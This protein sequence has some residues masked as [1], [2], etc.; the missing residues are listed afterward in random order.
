[1]G[2]TRLN[3]FKGEAEV[4]G[5]LKNVVWD[6]GALTI[7]DTSIEEAYA[8]IDACAARSISAV[9][10]KMAQTAPVIQEPSPEAL[11]H[12][13]ISKATDA[14]PAPSTNGT[15]KGEV[16]KPVAEKKPEPE[17]KAA[18]EASSGHEDIDLKTAN[19]IH[20]VN[21]LMDKG[22]KTAKE[23]LDQCEKIK[24]DVPVLAGPDMRSRVA[25]KLV[26]SFQMADALNA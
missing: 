1:M 7:F 11:A 19:I 18:P 2:I 5:A 4:G 12:A 10:V 23:I 20:V 6:N 22:F 24:A 16:E 3:G 14:K 25:R 9:R 8:I 17:K 15:K 26:S 21:H 13:G